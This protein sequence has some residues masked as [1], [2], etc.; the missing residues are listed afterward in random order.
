MDPNTFSVEGTTSLGLVSFS[1]DASLVA[2]SISEAGS[3]WRKISVIDVQTKQQIE[4]PILD[5]KFSGIS[6]LANIG[7]YYSSYDKPEGSELSARTDQHKLYFHRIGTR[8]SQ[9]K[10]IFGGIESEKYRYV[11]G[12]TTEDYAYLVISAATST[13]GNKLYIQPLKE[14]HHSRVTLLDHTNSD[15]HVLENIGSSLLLFTNLDAPNGK[16]V[17]YQ[18]ET[19]EW[20]DLIPEQDQQLNVSTGGGTLFATYMV[21]VLTKVKHYDFNGQLIREIDLPEGGQVSGFSGKR[22]QTEPNSF[23][24]LPTI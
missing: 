18:M 9:D 10:V 2:Y 3:D 6:W 4:A 1:K 24:H 7:F 20:A 19:G 21:D 5:A 14:D 15:T 13:S 12:Y 16:V 11:G 17:C 8:Q 22:E 23:S